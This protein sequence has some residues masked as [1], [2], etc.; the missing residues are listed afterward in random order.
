MN[1]KQFLK[2]QQKWYRK[3]ARSGF[4]DI[5]SPLKPGQ[6][7]KHWDSVDFQLDHTKESFLERQRYYELAGQLL[8]DFHFKNKVDKKIWE[9]HSNGV[10]LTIISEK[11]K[12]H[13]NTVHRIIKKYASYIKY[14]P[15]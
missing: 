11:V 7:L 5:E 9:M 8:H 1:P 12:L 4:K 6:P 2:L 3:L 13:R 15:D 10:S 14:N